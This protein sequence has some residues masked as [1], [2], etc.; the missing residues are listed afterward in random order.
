[1]ATPV[2]DMLSRR[3]RKFD[4]LS[5]M[6]IAASFTFLSDWRYGR[7]YYQD[8]TGWTEFLKGHAEAP[9]QYRIGVLFPAN[10][11]SNLTHLPLRHML[12][13]VDGIF[14]FLALSILFFLMSGNDSYPGKS[15]GGRGTVHCL[16]FALLLYY[17]SWL[18][19]YHKTETIANFACLAVAAALVAGKPR[20]P[21]PLAVI[22]LVLLSAYLGTVRADSGLALNV[23]IVAVALFPGGKNLPLGRLAQLAAG[24]IGVLAVVGVEYYIRYFMFPHAPYPASVFQL[25]TN[26]TTFV[27]VFCVVAALGPWFLVVRLAMRHWRRLEAWEC[28]L[29]VASTVEFIMFM[30]V[31]MSD[32]V[33]LFLPYC[34]ALVPTSALLLSYEL[35]GEYI[36]DLPD[37][38]IEIDGS[39][40]R[41]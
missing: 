28:A 20:V 30:V 24:S 38:T 40:L 27:G 1:M 16:S 26:L 2:P 8:P 7:E 4:W 31:A 29:V 21:V 23:G 32:E 17:M 22:A 3:L 25:L 14:L 37:T 6:F 11:L 9:G 12:S 10:F 39:T 5:I 36:R 15:Q 41:R 34:M 33:R 19:F 18:F 35:L 13:L